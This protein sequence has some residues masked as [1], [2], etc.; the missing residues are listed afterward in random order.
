MENSFETHTIILDSLEKFLLIR[1]SFQKI[2]EKF[3][4]PMN[5]FFN[6]NDLSKRRWSLQYTHS[7]DELMNQ[8]HQVFVE[9]PLGPLIMIW[10]GGK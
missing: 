10:L 2:L 9:Q 3:P 6:E 4:D 1:K 5:F 8:Q 7:V